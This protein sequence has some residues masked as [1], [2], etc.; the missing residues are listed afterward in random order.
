MKLLIKLL[1]ALIVLFLGLIIQIQ[2]SGAP[3][4][5]IKVV[6]SYQSEGYVKSTLLQPSSAVFRN[7]EGICGEVMISNINDEYL[8]YIATGKDA[9]L[10]DDHSASFE[11]LWQM[12]CALNDN[13][14]ESVVQ[15][16]SVPV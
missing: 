4:L 1:V 16:L 12:T 13:E 8:R 11:D 2:F 7:K 6:Q 14:R 5:L 10:I 9:V 15:K 3:N